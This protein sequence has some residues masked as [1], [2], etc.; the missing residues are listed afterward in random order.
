M[1]KILSSLLLIS[2]MA[3]MLGQNQVLVNEN[4]ES[5][6]L[7]NVGTDVTGATSGQG[8]IYTS[9]GTV[10]SYQIAAIDVANGKSFKLTSGT[11]APPVTGTNTNNRIAFKDFT[12]T[13]ATTGNNIVASKAKI[14]TGSA[15]GTGSIK[16]N[17]Y[18]I[19]SGTTAGY[20]GGIRYD[21]ATKSIVGEAYVTVAT[22]PTPS[23]GTVA[24]TFTPAQIFPAN[25]WVNVEHRYNKTNGTHQYFVNNAL[26]Y[27][28]NTGNVIVGGNTVVATTVSGSTAQLSVIQSTT[29]AGNTVANEAAIDDWNVIFSNTAALGT[30]DTKIV[31][32]LGVDLYPNPTSDFLNVKTKS[33]ITNISVADMTSRKVNVKLDGDKVDVRMLPGGTYLINIETK[34]GISTEKFIKK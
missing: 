13:I 16:L 33:K 32:K 20:I 2:T 34:D 31:S 1:K 28:Y 22:T 3:M 25:T 18:G 9:G 14:Y 29:L 8:G 11:G 27:T 5:L 23:A 17:T 10:T 24:L 30:D 12:A 6:I 15:T 19:L 21:Y 4:F 26:V 7:G